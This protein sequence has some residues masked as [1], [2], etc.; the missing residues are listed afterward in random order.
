MRKPRIAAL[1]LLPLAAAAGGIYS[2]SAS[3]STTPT[4]T[5]A[6]KSTLPFL[7]SFKI[8]PSQVVKSEK[9]DTVRPD[10]YTAGCGSGQ[11]SWVHLWSTG[12]WLLDDG[13]NYCV[14]DKG[15]TDLPD[16]A[17]AYFCSGNNSG[18][19][20]YSYNGSDYQTDFGASGSVYGIRSGGD[21]AVQVRILHFNISGWAGSDTCPAS[22]A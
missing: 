15:I 9:S 4:P 18:Y 6:V 13:P 17:I 11:Q 22:A 14:G 8:S 1:A 19:F 10:A 3:A 16:N 20:Q 5:H 21:G 7:H 12:N 2:G